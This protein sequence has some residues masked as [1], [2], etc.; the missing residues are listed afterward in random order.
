MHHS[1]ML[2][3]GFIAFMVVSV[4]WSIGRYYLRLRYI[5]EFK[6]P[7]AVIEKARRRRP[8]LG[9]ADWV[10]AERGLRDFFAAYLRS[11]RKPVSMPSQAVDDL[12]HEFIL[13]TRNYAQ[14]C[15]KA[16]GTFLHHTPSAAL[17]RHYDTNVGLRRV[18][19]QCCKL[20][21]IDPRAPKRLPLL[22]AIDDRLGLADG[23]RYTLDCR[24]MR[25]H[26]A[27]TATGASLTIGI[28]CATDMSDSSFDGTTDGFGDGGGGDSSG[29]GGGCSGGCGGD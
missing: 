9:Y 2:F 21:G 8:D 13:F 29:D 22:F 6:L 12:W 17:S 28:Q 27:A 11:G 4:L 25:A 19:W 23:Y 1:D 10:L 5:R 3:N 15:Q 18:W 14:F 24:S 7:R 20:E 26:T 16:F